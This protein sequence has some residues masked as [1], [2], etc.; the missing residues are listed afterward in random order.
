MQ[1]DQWTFDYR[2]VKLA[3]AVKAKIDHHQ[4]RL[5]YWRNKREEVIAIIR[6]EGIEADEK[7]G[8]AYTNPKARDWDRG[9]E[10][11]V[12]NDLR[13]DLTECFQKLAYHTERRDTYDGWRQVLE[14]N[15]QQ[16]LSLD[17]DD[18]LFFFGRDPGRDSW[19]LISARLKGFDLPV[20]WGRRVPH[21]LFAGRVAP[22][23]G[24]V[25]VRL[26]TLAALA[27]DS[28]TDSAAASHTNAH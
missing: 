12:R 21:C 14:A 22:G 18:W 2:A 4:E 20:P 5:A 16:V 3:E 24:P 8:L 19:G 26:R 13:K 10:I 6:A 25:Q 15:P 17:I 27:A 23:G 11:M 1:R 28:S 9:G 7:I